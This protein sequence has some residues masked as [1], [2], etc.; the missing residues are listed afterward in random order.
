M[1]HK[2][3]RRNFISYSA[4]AALGSQVGLGF[5]ASLRDLAPQSPQMRML[6]NAIARVDSAG[7]AHAMQA[8]SPATLVHIVIID[9]VQS[10]LFQSIPGEIPLGADAQEGVAQ[11][12]SEFRGLGLTKLFGDSLVGLPDDV[13]LCLNNGWESGT[14][15]HS[16]QNSYVSTRLGGINNAFEELSGGTGLF[17]PL[18]LS[19]RSDAND[20]ADC[21]VSGGM[22]R[23]KTFT[24]TSQLATTLQNS[25]APIIG[26]KENREML[27]RFDR[28]VTKNAGFRDTLAALAEQVSTA[29]PALNSASTNTDPIDQQVQAVI[30]LHKAGVARNFMITVPWDDTNGGGNLTTPG[31]SKRLDPFAGTA[32]IGKAMKDLHAAIPNL[33]CVWTSDGGRGLNNSDRSAG[34]AMMS[35]PANLIRNGYVGGQYT[36]TEQLGN[37]FTDVTL[38]SGAKMVSRPMHW[39]S[40]A[41]KALGFD[42]GVEYVSEALVTNKA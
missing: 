11:V 25:V 32:M 37:N 19:L 16:L 34:F 38:S 1:S 36:S 29:L 40:T 14:G 41:L 5:L 18:G 10:A 39:Y 3:S 17:G 7:V 4:T 8:T 22:R 30:A 2:I 24:S 31:G 42:A 27:D 13:A 20:S 33:V 12:T 23:M 6:G 21:F 9:K 35:G 28:V 15:G 26:S